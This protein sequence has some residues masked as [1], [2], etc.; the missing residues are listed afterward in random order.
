M[1]LLRLYLQ[2]DHNSTTEAVF[3]HP[4]PGPYIQSVYI[5]IYIYLYVHIY[6]YSPWSILR[7]LTVDDKTVI[8][9]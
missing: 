2:K 4:F 7:A 8:R 6:I 5:Y 1:P 9:G 3:I